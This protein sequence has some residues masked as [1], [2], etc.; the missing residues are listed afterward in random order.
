MEILLVSEKETPPEPISGET[1]DI[2][3]YFARC[4]FQGTAQQSVMFIRGEN[5]SMLLL[6]KGGFQSYGKSN[7]PL[8]LNPVK[9]EITTVTCTPKK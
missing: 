2:G 5:G 8:L 7:G 4:V 1:L 3:T 9:V 6:E